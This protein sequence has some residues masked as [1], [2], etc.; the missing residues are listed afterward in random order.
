MSNKTCYYQ[1]RQDVLQWLDGSRWGEAL[2][3]AAVRQ[4]QALRPKQE[5]SL[6]RKMA[7]GDRPHKAYHCIIYGPGD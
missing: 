6:E 2:R 4:R 5:D 7:L 1:D 3:M